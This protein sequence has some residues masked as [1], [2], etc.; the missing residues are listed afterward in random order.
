MLRLPGQNRKYWNPA[1]VA[2]LWGNPETGPAA[3]LV[4][5]PEVYEEPPIT[6]KPGKAGFVIVK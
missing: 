5:F 1:E 3:V 2:I 6:H 4:C